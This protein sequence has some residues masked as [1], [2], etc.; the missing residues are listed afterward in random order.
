[1][2]YLLPLLNITSIAE[3]IDQAIQGQRDLI[4]FECIIS[5]DNGFLY[6]NNIMIMTIKE[7]LLEILRVHK[8]FDLSKALIFHN[9]WWDVNLL[10]TLYFLTTF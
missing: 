4:S 5:P 3:V 9:S 1:M 8:L 7:L 2:L 10:Y 6:L